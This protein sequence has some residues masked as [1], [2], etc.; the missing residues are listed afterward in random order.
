MGSP[1]ARIYAVVLGTLVFMLAW[2]AIAAHPW[3]SAG[4]GTR[5]ARL[6]ALA[7]RER[8]LRREAAQVQR[9]VARRWAVYRRALARRNAARARLIS[10]HK[11]AL[12]QTVSAVSA[13]TGGGGG[14]AAPA[15]APAV[16]VVTLP[17]ATIT[18]TS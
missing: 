6:A 18:R 15:A 7:A 9:I 12:A 2:A 3:A 13:P 14:Y 16:R 8:Q 5:D 4:R 11:A 17:A 1:L 10:Q